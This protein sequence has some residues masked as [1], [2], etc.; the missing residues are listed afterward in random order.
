MGTP[1]ARNEFRKPL[2]I[3]RLLVSDSRIL[4]HCGGSTIL[5]DDEPSVIAT[6]DQIRNEAVNVN[7]P[8]TEWGA[9]SSPPFIEVGSVLSL[10]LPDHAC[11]HV[12]DVDVPYSISPDLKALCWISTSQ[13]HVADI[14]GQVDIRRFQQTIHLP[15]RFHIRADVRMERALEPKLTGDLDGNLDSRDNLLPEAI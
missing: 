2:S 4:R 9:D 15:R 10:C 8:L 5:L 6:R 7:V 1:R 13:L 11:I 12:L 3:A 14:E